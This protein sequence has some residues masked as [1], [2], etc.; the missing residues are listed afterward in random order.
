MLHAQ[1]RFIQ[2]QIKTP[3]LAAA[4]LAQDELHALIAYVGGLGSAEVL[5]EVI[6]KAKVA[7]GIGPGDFLEDWCRNARLRIAEL[8][9]GIH[10]AKRPME[11]GFSLDQFMP[12]LL[13]EDADAF[14]T[15][16]ESADLSGAPYHMRM[17][18]PIE[19]APKDGTEIDMWCPDERGGCRYPDAKWMK[20]KYE[21][22][23]GEY[24]WHDWNP[25]FEW[26][27]IGGIPTHWMPLPDPP[28]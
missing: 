6:T 12:G 15:A 5:A 20:C 7:A 19:T 23:K 8:E 28:A 17:W 4:Q 26:E 13:P 9:S 16:L 2:E 18:Q 21:P 1:F 25:E 22:N 10:P 24:A 11:G 3:S 14:A 27:P